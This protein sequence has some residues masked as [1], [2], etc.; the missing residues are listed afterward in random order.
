MRIYL[1]LGKIAGN[2]YKILS[3]KEKKIKKIKFFHN[4]PYLINQ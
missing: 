2:F 4:L 1:Y 3:K